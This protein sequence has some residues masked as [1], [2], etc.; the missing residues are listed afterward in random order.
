MKY[1][2]PA[3]SRTLPS[4]GEGWGGVINVPHID[5]MCCNKQLGTNKL[6]DVNQT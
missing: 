3:L 6:N 4:R 5:E 1:T 2:P